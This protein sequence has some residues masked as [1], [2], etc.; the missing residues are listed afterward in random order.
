[1][2]F[3]RERFEAGFKAEADELLRRMEEGLGALRGGAGGGA[4]LGGMT[5]AAHTLRGSSTMMGYA[6][7]AGMARLI[8]ISLDRARVGGVAM[9]AAQ[10][11]LLAECLRALRGAMEHRAEAPG[12]ADGLAER[13]KRLFGPGAP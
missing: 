12:S 11:D 8:E 6:A 3:D 2:G 9:G 10:L 1:M 13:A 4:L 5:Q 7:A